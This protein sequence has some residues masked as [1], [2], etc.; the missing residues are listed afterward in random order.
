M[1]ARDCVVGGPD[2]LGIH[3]HH[4]CQADIKTTVV[5]GGQT[6]RVRCAAPTYRIRGAIRWHCSRGILD[7]EIPQGR[8]SGRSAGAEPP[9]SRQ[10]W[11]NKEATGAS[12]ST[13][14]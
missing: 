13:R 10:T 5:P 6:V 7:L 2:G 12:H 14:L 9:A 3:G 4:G 1:V 8:I 11:G